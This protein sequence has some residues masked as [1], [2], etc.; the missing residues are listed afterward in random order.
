MSH[1]IERAKERYGVTLTWRDL[2]A[3]AKKIA[4]GDALLQMTQPDGK[5]HY[6]VSYDGRAFRAVYS[7][8]QAI[9]TFLPAQGRTFV[10]A[11]RKAR[12]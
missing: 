6:L 12:A 9:V 8:T 5:Q 2:C 1:A 10:R 7:V 11:H 4:D 3:M